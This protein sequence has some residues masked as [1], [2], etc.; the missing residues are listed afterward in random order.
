MKKILIIE[1]DEFL[2]GLEATKIVKSGFTIITAQRGEEAMVKILEPNINII[3]LDLLLPNF[4][5][6]EILKKIR[7]NEP[8]KKTPVIVFSNLSD[9]KDIE[10]AIDLGANKFMIKSNFSL[11]ELVEQ[12]NKLVI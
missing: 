8:T 1:D 3:L 9:N 7:S 10:K 6:Y 5:G 2:Q 4:D 12:I 11:E